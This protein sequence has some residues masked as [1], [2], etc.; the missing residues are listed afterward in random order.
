MTISYSPRNPRTTANQIPSRD[1]WVLRDD[2]VAGPQRDTGAARSYVADAGTT[3]YKIVGYTTADASFTGA[4][5]S[6]VTSVERLLTSM[7]VGEG[8]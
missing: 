2:L 5:E 3:P 8:L 4:A 6:T 1:R 7:C